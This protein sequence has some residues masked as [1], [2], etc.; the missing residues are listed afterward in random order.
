M[1][2]QAM[3]LCDVTVTFCTI[4]KNIFEKSLVTDPI[5]Q[6]RFCYSLLNRFLKIFV[7]FEISN[8]FGLNYIIFSY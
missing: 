7:M 5:F 8:V 6:P 3:T 1:E 4:I 2:M